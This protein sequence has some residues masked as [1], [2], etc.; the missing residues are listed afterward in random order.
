MNLT[1]IQQSILRSLS[2]EW[3]APKQIIGRLPKEYADLTSI[4]QSLKVLVSEGLV[5]VNPVMLGLY[6]LTK[7]GENIQNEWSKNE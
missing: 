7:L 2:T 3:K 6:R 5:Q 4:N 1:P